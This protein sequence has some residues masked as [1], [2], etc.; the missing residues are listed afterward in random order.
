MIKNEK[1]RV[2][3]WLIYQLPQKFMLKDNVCFLG[4]LLIIHLIGGIVQK[5]ERCDIK[6]FHH[7]GIFDLEANIYS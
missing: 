4:D 1:N 3:R 6:I 7:L 2:K 5:N